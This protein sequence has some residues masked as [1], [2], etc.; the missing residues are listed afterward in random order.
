MFAIGTYSNIANAQKPFYKL[1]EQS[2]AANQVSNV[3]IRQNSTDGI[4]AS[5]ANVTY[6]NR[7]NSLEVIVTSS[8]I[9]VAEVRVVGIPMLR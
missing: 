8:S 3:P 7:S 9:R 6:V 5:I 1:L 4:Y 2:P